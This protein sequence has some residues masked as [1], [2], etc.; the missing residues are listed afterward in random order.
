[1]AQVKADDLFHL[2]V[3]AHASGL[4]INDCPYPANTNEHRV[5]RTG[6]SQARFADK[7]ENVH[8]APRVSSTK[9]RGLAR[10]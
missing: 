7:D 8:D 1:V 2:G 6:W 10:R 5:W 9:R 4:S 3:E